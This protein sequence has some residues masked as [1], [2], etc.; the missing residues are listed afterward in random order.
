MT[1]ATTPTPSLL[2]TTP[3][4]EIVRVEPI[5]IAW[6]AEHSVF[7]SEQFLKANG[8]DY[9]WLG[10]FDKAGGLRGILPYTVVRKP[11][12]RMV[13]FRVETMPTADGL[14]VSSEKAFLNRAM[15]YFAASGADLVLP[16]SNN[17]IFRTYPDGALAA[18][19]GSYVIDLT[20]PEE[21]LW[22]KLH[23]KHRNKVR[24]AMKNDVVISRGTGQL[25]DAFE[26]IRETLKRSSLRFMS[27]DAFRNYVDRLGDNIEIFTAE[28]GGELQGCAIAPYSAHS[29]YYVYGGSVPKPQTGAINFLHWEAIRWFR[30]QGVRRYDFVGTRIDPDKGSKQDRLRMFKERFGGTLSKGYM[31]KYCFRRFK[32]GFYNCAVRMLRGGDIV[33][34]ESHK[35]VAALKSD[36]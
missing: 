35:L 25:E 21:T 6:G 5:P 33:D 8:D 16:A 27:F 26:L 1:A 19:Y 32:F 4:D 15:G 11:A 31:W 13:R 28:H 29:A 18:P 17:T 23:S 2:E 20:L 3:P 36:A 24:N 22:S 9:G 12:L 34:L 14:S 30:E 10:G 7:A